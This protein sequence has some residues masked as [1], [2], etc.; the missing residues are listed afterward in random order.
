M[1]GDEVARMRVHVEEY[2]AQ[3]KRLDDERRLAR[4]RGL[5]ADSLRLELQDLRKTRGRLV[6][7]VG[8]VEDEVGR[9]RNLFLE[10]FD[11]A[12]GKF[13]R[14]ERRVKVAEGRVVACDCEFAGKR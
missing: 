5:D 9:D 11:A 4:R 14:N 10:F 7:L 6:G 13:L 3:R 1:L 8:E 2:V 12:R